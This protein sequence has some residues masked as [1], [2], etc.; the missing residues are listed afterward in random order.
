M[1]IKRTTLKVYLK[2]FIQEFLFD[3]FETFLAELFLFAAHQQ[4]YFLI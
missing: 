2:P 1:V 4:F 3:W